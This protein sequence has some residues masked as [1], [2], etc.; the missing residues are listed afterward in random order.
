MRGLQKAG[1]SVHAVLTRSACR[2]IGPVTFE[3]L[4][5]NPVVTGM[6]SRGL[7]RE[8]E[9]IR[10]AQSIDI[11]AV[12]PAT[13]NALGKFANGIADDFLST[14]YLSCP[15]PVLLAPAMNVEMWNHP[16]VRRNVEIL[17]QRGVH[18]VNPGSG[19]LACGMEGEGRLAEVDDIVSRILQVAV[20]RG[21]LSR[22]RLLVTAGPTVEDLDPV[23]F[24][25]NR[26]S[27]KMGYAVAQAAAARGS[28]VILVSG[29]TALPAPAGARLVP[30]RSAAEMK[31]AVLGHFGETDIVVKAAAVSDYRPLEVAGEKIR[32]GARELAMRMIANDD[33]LEQ[34]GREKRSQILVGFAAETTDVTARAREKMIRKNLDFIVANDVSGGV[35]GEDCATVHIL[36]AG[37]AVVT[38]QHQTK[39]AI[40][41][42]ILDMAAALRDSRGDP[43]SQPSGKA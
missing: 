7:N 4:S 9:H 13:A 25:S 20:P 43:P 17:Q 31:A 12:A 28:Q 38:L 15:S 10:L 2:F 21:D 39:L 35:F 26:S 3:A 29:P 41:N 19:M 30:V 34:L 24:V 8:I 27:G 33:I 11:L 37:G 40:A 32:K 5:G 42:R 23:R 1:A 6:F 22:V 14:L 16:A 36:E 18:F